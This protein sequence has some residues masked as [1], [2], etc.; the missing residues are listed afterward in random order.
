MKFEHL[1]DIR[2]NLFDGG[3]AA[4][5]EGAGAAAPGQTGT[6]DPGE[7]KAS[8]APTRRGKSGEFQNVLFGKQEP[9]QSAADRGG[10]AA[11]T[12]ADGAGA[13]D[14]G[15]KAQSSDAGSDTKP[16]VT[17]TSDTLEAKRKAFQELVNGEYKDIYTEETQRI[18]NRRFKET[19][20]LE[21]QVG[22][23]QPVIDM[24]MQRY[25][26][27]DGDIAK[28]TAAIE[29]DDAYW[30]EAAEEAGMS[31][32]QYKQFQKLQ[33]ENAALLREQQQ[34][35]SQQAAQQQLQKWYGEAEQ[36]KSLYPSF[37]LNVEV[38]N[39]QF[40]SMLKAG[41][42]V[43]HAYEVIHMDE[44]K[45]G[46]AKMQAQ[47]TEKQVV[48]GIRAR[49]ARPPEN[50]TASQS[51]FTVKDDPS[52]WSKKDRAEVARRVARGETIKL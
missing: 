3:A 43:Q 2:L 13:A 50:G 9:A 14:N 40:L 5:G 34:R 24:L 51:A 39:P 19:Q 38:K 15:Q 8:P 49:G 36:T 47:A 46:V 30:S 7:T 48:D 42:P 6:G 20:N 33:R 45:A 11:K 12:A 23:T 32:E 25:K 28:L 16:G 31:V 37:D 17:V 1:L 4:G 26:I 41:V 22:R 10:N 35:S 29:N 27:A 52:K 18:I 44:I 21:K